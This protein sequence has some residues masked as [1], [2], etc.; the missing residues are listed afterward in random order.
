MAKY[1]RL[2]LLEVL[3][4]TTK[5][6][7]YWLVSVLAIYEVTDQQYMDKNDG[8]AGMIIIAVVLVLVLIIVAIVVVLMME[9]VIFWFPHVLALLL[10]F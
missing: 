9:I 1:F 8:A 10:N 6:L 7:E 3:T 2:P 5:I 4:K